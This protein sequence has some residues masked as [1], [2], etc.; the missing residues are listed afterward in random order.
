LKCPIFGNFSEIT[1][2]LATKISQ[3]LAKLILEFVSVKLIYFLHFL[4]RKMSKSEIKR[5]YIVIPERKSI[6]KHLSKE[7]GS[8]SKGN[9]RINAQ[10]IDTS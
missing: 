8:K 5:V 4:Q 10:V 3:L 6:Q 9:K 1:L 7:L 2:Q